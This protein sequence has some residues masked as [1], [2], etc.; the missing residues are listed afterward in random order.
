MKWINKLR[1]TA[2]PL[3]FPLRLVM[4]VLGNYHFNT[5]LDIGCGD[6]SFIDLLSAKHI[7]N[8][9]VGVESDVFYWG[10]SDRGLPI[11][12][13]NSLTGTFDLLIF[14]DVLHHIDNKPSFILDY[15]DRFATEECFLLIK[16]MSGEYF[17]PKYFN[18][19]H[20]LV[21]AKQFISEVERESLQEI[22][23]EF[24]LINY[25]RQQIFL[26]NHYCALFKRNRALLI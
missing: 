17:I 18:R 15:I 19:L 25:E 1:S 16:E 7:V 5:A 11:I 2:R 24:D 21:L 13:P 6:G 9:A 20:D 3:I 8:T 12:S 10:K 26:Y 4:N 14:N 22:L 23:T